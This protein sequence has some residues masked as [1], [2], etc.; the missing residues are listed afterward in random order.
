MIVAFF[1]VYKLF[2]ISK[3]N[4]IS[5]NYNL[6]LRLKETTLKLRSRFYFKKEKTYE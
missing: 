1:L 4:K 6:Y 5:I 2:E 3:I